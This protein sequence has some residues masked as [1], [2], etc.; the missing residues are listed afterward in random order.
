MKNYY[1][2]LKI[3]R[4][5]TESEIAKAYRKR[6]LK[7]HPDRV[8]ESEKER[9][10]EK[11]KKLLEAYE[12]LGHQATRLA[13]DLANPPTPREMKEEKKAERKEEKKA[14]REEKPPSPKFKSKY[15]NCHVCQTIIKSGKREGEVC[16][17]INC[18]ITGHDLWD[19]KSTQEMTHWLNYYHG[20]PKGDPRRKKFF[21]VGKIG[22]KRERMAMFKT[23]GY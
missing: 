18:W 8:P 20:L 9:A 7:L 13:Y 17:R 21:G 15:S 23:M 6:A 12:I 2:I 22:R 4:S 19:E 3:P 5:A 10:T 16:K 1:K 14:E 11:F